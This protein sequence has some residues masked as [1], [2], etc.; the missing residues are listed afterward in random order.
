MGRRRACL[1]LAQPGA[2]GASPVRRRGDGGAYR[3]R[4]LLE[5]VPISLELIHGTGGGFDQGLRFAHG[6]SEA[7]FQVIARSRFGYLRSAFPED[8]SPVHQAAVLV[9]LLDHLG[10]DQVAVAGGSAG[11]LTA[12][13]FAL[14]HA[15]R[16]SHLVR[17]VPAANLTGRDPVEFTALQ[18]CSALWSSAC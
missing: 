3:D 5:G 9:E 14:R 17:I 18:R 4:R 10:L 7:G 12:A 6:L 15:D 1:D 2:L 11:A 13:E 16:C 8:A